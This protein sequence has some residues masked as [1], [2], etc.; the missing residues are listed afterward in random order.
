MLVLHLWPPDRSA[1]SPET[2]KGKTGASEVGNPGRA[3]KCSN[4]VHVGLGKGSDYCR[5]CMR[6]QKGAVDGRNKSWAETQRS[7]YA[8]ILQRG[9]LNPGVGS[10]YAICAGMRGTTV[11]NILT[12]YF[13]HY[14]NKVDSMH[15]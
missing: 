5:Q 7:V 3:D 15:D 4:D 11:T 1:A 13:I 9:V 2:S 8:H 14:V 12:K 6:K 10:K